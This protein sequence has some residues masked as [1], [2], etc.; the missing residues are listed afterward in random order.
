MPKK[1]KGNVGGEAIKVFVRVRPPISNEVNEENAVNTPSNTSVKLSSSKH[2][3]TCSYDHVF[4]ELTR[5]FICV[6]ISDI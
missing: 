5:Y 4:S 3:V 6:L 1:N 2:N